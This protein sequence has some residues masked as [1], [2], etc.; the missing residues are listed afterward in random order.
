MCLPNKPHELNSRNSRNTAEPNHLQFLL[1]TNVALVQ[2]FM[3]V[4]GAMSS[5]EI[6]TQVASMGPEG[7]HNVNSEIFTFIHRFRNK[8][9]S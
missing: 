8:A 1:L 9:C 3:S 2:N 4:L 6:F 5:K 7:N